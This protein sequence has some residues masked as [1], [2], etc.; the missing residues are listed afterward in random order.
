MFEKPIRNAMYGIAD[1]RNFFAHNLDM[2]FSSSFPKMNTAVAKLTLH[3]GRTHYPNPL[4]DQESPYLLEP[5]ADIRGKFLV[6]LKL[7][8][9]WLFGDNRRHQ[10]FSNAPLILMTPDATHT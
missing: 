1:I 2:T 8:L 10:P 7:C 6:N 3:E 4:T 9:L 5:T